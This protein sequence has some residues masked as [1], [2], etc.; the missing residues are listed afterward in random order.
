MSGFFHNQPAEDKQRQYDRYY[1]GERGNHGC[2]GFILYEAVY[3][4]VKR[5][6]NKRYHGGQQNSPEK[7][8]KHTQ[9][10]VKQEQQYAKE[11]EAKN[12]AVVEL[13]ELAQFRLN[14]HKAIIL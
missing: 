12:M 11:K 6:E 8:R 4:K 2:G 3:P 10:L 9:Q 14:I 13:K 7:R 1:S 5:I